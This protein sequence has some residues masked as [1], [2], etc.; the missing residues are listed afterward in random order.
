[1]KIYAETKCDFKTMKAFTYL[2]AFRTNKPGKKV[3]L[4]SV[5]TILLAIILW[6]EIQLLGANAFFVVTFILV[7]LI[8]ALELYL[9][10]GL[11]VVRFR[12]MGNLMGCKHAFRFE[13]EAFTVMSSDTGYSSE[14]TIG[15]KNLEKVAETPD[16]FYI[17]HSK[18]QVF[19]VNK[20]S[21]EEGTEGQLRQKLVE[22]LNGRY[23]IYKA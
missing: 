12:A 19:I 8:L 15:Y 14:C 4:F 7:L 1:M 2:S 9:Y 18:T 10:F 13:D 17:F 23:K 6:L 16:Y 3:L 21:M 22:Y 11:P 20:S 5:I